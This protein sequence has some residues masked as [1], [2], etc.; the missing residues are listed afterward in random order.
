PLD[1]Y[2]TV[3]YETQIE[4]NSE[5]IRLLADILEIIE[6]MASDYDGI[7]ACEPP[8][9]MDALLSRIDAQFNHI[10]DVIT[11]EAHHAETPIKH[12]EEHSRVSI[13]DTANTLAEN[14]PIENGEKAEN[15]DDVTIEFAPSEDNN[16]E[17][18][19]ELQPDLSVDTPRDLLDQRI[20]ID[21]SEVQFEASSEDVVDNFNTSDKLEK[22]SVEHAL[23]DFNT[24]HTVETLADSAIELT[25]EDLALDPELIEIFSHEAK[26]V[27]SNIS[28]MLGDWLAN[29]RDIPTM[30]ELQRTLHTLRSGAKMAK[31]VAISDLCDQMESALSHYVMSNID[32]GDHVI[33]L[34]TECHAWLSNVVVDLSAVPTQAPKN[35][36]DRL[37]SVSEVAQTLEIDISDSGS[38][39]TL[40]VDTLNLE[41][42]AA[43]IDDELVAIFL[44]EASELVTQTESV[45]D[46]ILSDAQNI[47]N[48]SSL[49]RL[50]HTLKGGARMAGIMSI[51]NITHTVESVLEQIVDHTQQIDERATQL[52]LA[53]N[54]WINEAIGQVRNGQLVLLPPP[55]LIHDIE[56]LIQI[57]PDSMSG[58]ASIAEGIE[59]TVAVEEMT[60]T[61][62]G[63][64]ITADNLHFEV[65]GQSSN[66]N[67][68]LSEVTL[69]TFTASESTEPDS[70]KP[71][72]KAL[73][74]SASAPVSFEVETKADEEDVAEIILPEFTSNT[75]LVEPEGNDALLDDDDLTEIFLEEADEIQESME[76][77]L[78]VWQDDVANIE[79]I[80]NMQRALHTLK[81]GARMAG[82]NSVG[83]ISHEIESMLEDVTERGLKPTNQMPYVVQL[84]HDWLVHAIIDLKAGKNPA[85]LS[86]LEKRIENLRQ[87]KDMNLGVEKEVASPRASPRASERQSAQSLSVAKKAA[88]T[89]APVPTQDSGE[90][91]QLSTTIRTGEIGEVPVFRTSSRNPDEQIRVKA[92]L[93][94]TLVNHAGEMNIYNSRIEQQLLGWQF[95]LTELNHTVERLHE[96][97]RKFE[98]EAETQI[99]Y[100]HNNE[101]TDANTDF[102]PLELDRFSYMQQLSRGMVESLGDLNNI[103]GALDNISSDADVLLLQQSRINSDL[104]DGLMSTRLTPFSSS[105]ARLRRVVRQTCQELGKQAILNVNGA[106]GEMDR[107]QLNRVVPALEHI[108]RNAVDHGLETP[109]QRKTANKLAEGRIDINFFQA[110]S[111][112]VIEI[113]DDGAGI[114]I[115][116]LRAKA[117][118][119]QLITNSTELSDQEMI[120]F[121]LESGFSTATN[122]TQISGRGVGMDVVNNEIK[123]LNGS[124]I[125]DSKL[126]KGSTFT[127]RLPLTVLVNQALML[128]VNDCNYALPLSGIDHITR[129]S[130]GELNKMFSD[131]NRIYEFAGESYDLIDVNKIL[132]GFHHKQLAEGSKCPLILAHS[133]E[134]RVALHID[135]IMGRQEIVI[136]SVGPQLSSLANISGATILPN[137][138]VALIL[139]LNSI[140]RSNHTLQ[141]MIDAGTVPVDMGSVVV[142]EKTPLVMIVDD[143][144]TVRKVT[145]RL[146][147]RHDFDTIT[148]K[149]GV[150]ALTVLLEELP[151]VMLL[152]VEMPRM[153]GFELANTMRNDERLKNIPIIMI[154]SRTG[155]KH[156]DRALKIGV[157]NYM[158]KPYHEQELLDNIYGL[159]KGSSEKEV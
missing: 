98:I 24:E 41:E 71:E 4:I 32:P 132:H 92:D 3:L 2:F 74:D 18:T 53:F 129:I 117:I 157:N 89:E 26:E 51:A 27:L 91:I 75:A 159:I 127:I 6:P 25:Q 5:S 96:Q 112:I 21:L 73:P 114:N 44:E 78:S 123:Q 63:D 58:S 17:L 97:L 66:D 118:E 8:A 113:S 142:E 29:T 42:E 154:T 107:S 136:K 79:H 47:E 115:D 64:N 76:E 133:G 23:T 55:K 106:D 16:H 121:I 103:Q 109:D 1:K 9:N 120:N 87:G 70:T 126:G 40:E 141:Q 72:S 28:E 54:E 57:S 128:S 77:I 85:P 7:D 56:N 34:F 14:V 50:L 101:V 11:R 151:D 38:Q 88:R 52:L 12:A 148:A 46:S 104:H 156:R 119:R 122:V 143:S 146:L 84:C 13:E 83:N 145:E 137:G 125:I 111:E 49:R 60:P 100:R 33:N 124:L 144:I 39:S 138:G 110:G 82:I 94:D 99:M 80:M 152:D 140:I 130:S 135:L 149:D 48:I 81:G 90:L 68:Q 45:L 108:L 19:A 10:K 153:D 37:L 35:L 36:I 30:E 158:G 105:I 102:D 134:Q 43:R 131:N 93:I 20:A 62:L 155:D 15:S 150:D 69:E 65:E 95:N 116:L 147:K 67:A 22:E 59:S 31:Q 86:L 61:E 139:D